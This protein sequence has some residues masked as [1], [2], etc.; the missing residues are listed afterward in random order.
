[1]GRLKYSPEK[2]IGM[3]R[4]TE[5]KLSQGMKAG[6]ICRDLGITTNTYYRWRSNNNV[7]DHQ[8]VIIEF[9]DGSTATHNMIGGVSKPSRS[10]HLIGTKGEVQGVFEENRFVIRHIDPRPKHEYSE[11]TITVNISGD[12]HGAFGGHLIGFC[13]EDSREKRCVVDIPDIL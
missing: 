7:V 10:I 13:S 4:E 12:M 11:E 9:K 3:L 5:V 1:M 6:Q 8:S 2:I